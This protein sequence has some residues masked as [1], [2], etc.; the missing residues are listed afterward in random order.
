ME[1][2]VYGNISSAEYYIQLFKFITTHNV[3]TCPTSA[4]FVLANSTKCSPCVNPTPL[5]D[6]NAMTCISGCPT[7]TNFN[8][9]ERTCVADNSC[10]L[11]GQLFNVSSKK[12]ECATSTPYFTGSACVSCRAPSYW[13][14]TI[15]QCLTCDL[16]KQEYFNTVSQQCAKCPTSAPISIGILCTNCNQTSYYDSAAGSCVLCPNNRLFNPVSQKC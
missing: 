5:F 10:S 6:A 4:P 2:W 1:N 11:P 8:Q 12:C 13:N 15:K 14:Q 9:A 7:G 3:T 16:A